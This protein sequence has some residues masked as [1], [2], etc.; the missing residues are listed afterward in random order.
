LVKKLGEPKL[1]A[2]SLVLTALSMA[3]LPF[4]KGATPLSW[5]ILFRAEGGGWVVMLAALGLLSVGT[6]LTRPPLFG[7]LSNLT[8]AHEQGANIGVAQGA[9]SLARI[10]G[11]VFATALLPY[12][13]PA[14]YLACAAILVVT[15]FLMRQR[16]SGQWTAAADGGGQNR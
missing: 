15:T 2:L 4:I 7:L 14:P 11:P 5:G 9:G 1:I 10:L 16:W 3:A 6:A 12:W 13:P 8:A